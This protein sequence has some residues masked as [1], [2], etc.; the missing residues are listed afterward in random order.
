MKCNENEIH[1]CLVNRAERD[2][3][4]CSRKEKALRRLDGNLPVPK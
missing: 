4:D 3:F 1:V 2:G